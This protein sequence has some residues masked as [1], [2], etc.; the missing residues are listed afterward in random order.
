MT[1]SELNKGD[2]RDISRIGQKRAQPPDR[3]Q[4]QREPKLIRRAA[5]LVD[6][7]PVRVIQEEDPVQLHSR[8]RTIKATIR[9]RLRIGQELD[10][11]PRTIAM[12]IRFRA[13][14]AT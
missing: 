14:L 5:A 11:H 8:R 10:R 2:Q 1:G 12:I 3:R 13:R 7:L 4:L 9:R 6:Q